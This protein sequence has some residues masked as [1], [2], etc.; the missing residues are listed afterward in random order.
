MGSLQHGKVEARANI[1]ARGKSKP[2][3]EVFWKAKTTE[4]T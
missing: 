2:L 4:V 1:V 3:Q